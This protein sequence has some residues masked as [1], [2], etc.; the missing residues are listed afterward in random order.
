MYVFLA[1]WVG[2]KFIKVAFHV[3]TNGGVK[4]KLCAFCRHMIAKRLLPVFVLS[5]IRKNVCLTH[6]TLTM[7]AWNDTAFE[8]DSMSLPFVALLQPSATHTASDSTA[9]Q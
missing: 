8:N 2:F 6:P 7:S 9:K 5:F 3:I 1:V 4:V